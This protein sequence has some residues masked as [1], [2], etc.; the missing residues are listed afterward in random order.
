MTIPLKYGEFM[1]DGL[2]FGKGK[3]YEPLIL[4]NLPFQK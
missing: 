1:E 3:L 4:Y 2:T